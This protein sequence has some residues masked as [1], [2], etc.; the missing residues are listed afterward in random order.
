MT[1]QP[2][3][4]DELKNPETIECPECGAT[5]KV[6]EWWVEHSHDVQ[7][8]DCAVIFPAKGATA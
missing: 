2:E 5:G 8:K 3:T 1:Q 7:C 6:P 4:E